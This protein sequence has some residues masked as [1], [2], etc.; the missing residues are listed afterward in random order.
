MRLLLLAFSYLPSLAFAGPL[1]DSL[2]ISAA[3]DDAKDSALTVGSFV[4][5][6][7]AMLASIPAI[8]K[9]VKMADPRTTRLDQARVSF[10][11]Y[12]AYTTTP[13]ARYGS[14]YKRQGYE[15]PVVDSLYTRA[16]FLEFSAR[17]RE[18][19]AE[20][21]KS[22]KEEMDVTDIE[23]DISVAEQQMRTAEEELEEVRSQI[24][25]YEQNHELDIE[26]AEIIDDSEAHE[27]DESL[28]LSVDELDDRESGY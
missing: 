15:N 25:F 9:M 28:W 18:R 2:G 13:N 27:S 10:D 12:K 4:I 11:G 23:T 17:L 3:L 16:E 19:E 26:D 1:A 24:E 8:I 20:W 6:F 22:Q 5:L 7:V 21:L 14:S